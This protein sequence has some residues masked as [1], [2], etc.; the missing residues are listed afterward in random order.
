MIHT[1]F[2]IGIFSL[3]FM[4]HRPSMWIHH[5][6]RARFEVCSLVDQKNSS[7][8]WEPSFLIQYVKSYESEVHSS[9]LASDHATIVIAQDGGVCSFHHYWKDLESDSSVLMRYI[10]SIYIYRF[11]LPLVGFKVS[12]FIMRHEW[13]IDG[14]RFFRS[15]FSVIVSLEV[16][17]A[18]RAL[19][20]QLQV[21]EKLARREKVHLHIIPSTKV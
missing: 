10:Y 2:Q 16:Q 8:H 17:G 21:D 5:H 7:W 20:W 15:L 4:E 19:A 6:H 9:A 12:T 11:F 14:S 1:S 3:F 18:L 13:R